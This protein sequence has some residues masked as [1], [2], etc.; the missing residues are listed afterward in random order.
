MEHLDNLLRHVVAHVGEVALA[1][2][3]SKLHKMAKEDYT[4]DDAGIDLASFKDIC[5]NN[6]T[7]IFGTFAMQTELVEKIGGRRFW[8]EL[9]RQRELLKDADRHKFRSRGMRGLK[10]LEE[11]LSNTQTAKQR[12]REHL[13][14]KHDMHSI[15][16][17]M[18][19][20]IAER[21]YELGH[22]DPAEVEEE[23]EEEEPPALP[24]LPETPRPP[25]DPT[26]HAGVLQ[27]GDIVALKRNVT[28]ASVSAW[29]GVSPLDVGEILS[30]E[31]KT[32]QDG[33]DP[34]PDSE[35]HAVGARVCARVR[36]SIV[37]AK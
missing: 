8:G 36:A 28:R 13:D 24:A 26:K 17:R 31:P 15:R 2:L 29:A 35:W 22:P 4:G 33:R 25:A 19:G 21:R 6:P 16:E 20:Q 7:I 3:H 1:S 32:G 37:A 34:K 12:E 5:H 23:E 27:V 30:I 14:S 10:E 18:C 11:E 9:K